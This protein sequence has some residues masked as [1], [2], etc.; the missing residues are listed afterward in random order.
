M[1]VTKHL[2]TVALLLALATNAVAL[3]RS[4]GKSVDDS[5]VDVAANLQLESIKAWALAVLQAQDTQIKNITNCSKT[6]RF[7]NGSACVTPPMTGT[8]NN[9]TVAVSTINVTGQQA[10]YQSHCC[11]KKWGVCTSEKHHHQISYCTQPTGTTYV[12]DG[13]ANKVNVV[14]KVCTPGQITWKC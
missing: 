7:W 5:R 10:H 2:C 13:P 6:N 4:A 8:M 1:S 11:K 3:E 14:S 12:I 9:P